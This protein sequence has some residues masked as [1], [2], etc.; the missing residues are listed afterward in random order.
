VEISLFSRQ[1]LG[2]QRIP[3]LATLRS[4]A[5]AWNQRI[6]RDRVMI[7]WNFSRIDAPAVFHYQS[8]LFPRAE[9]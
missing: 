9:Y 8:N 6:N 4:E 5:E 1:C 3:D 7:R 2:T